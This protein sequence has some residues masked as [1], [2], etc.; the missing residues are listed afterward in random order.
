MN[1][2]RRE[3]IYSILIIVLIPLLFVGNTLLFTSHLRKNFDTE[4]G[5]KA[6][7]VNS[8]IAQSVYEHL[9]DKN[10]QETLDTLVINVKINHPEIQNIRI[11]QQASIGNYDV[12]ANAG[13][14]VG[15]FSGTDFTQFDLAAIH[16]RSVT[17]LIDVTTSTGQDTRAWDTATPII[18]NNK[19][20]VAY[21]S[22]QML[23]TDGDILVDN[24]TNN[25]YWVTLASTIL[26][27]L[28][29]AR[30]FRF[31]TY[32]DLLR[33]QK[34][35]NQTMNDFLNVASHE[36][37]AP[38]TII[39][40]IA[41]NTKD[42]LYGEVPEKIKPQ[43][44]T[45]MDQTMRLST[46]VS[47]LLNISRIQSGK[48]SFD[49][50][51]VNM[52]EIIT[53]LAGNYKQKAAEKNM[54]ITYLPPA[55]LPPV[56]ADAGRVQE[57]ITN[58]IDNALKYSLQ[59]SVVISHE[60]KGNNVITRVKDTGIGMS[61]EERSRLFQRFYRVQNDKTRNIAGT[62]LGLWIIKQYIEKMGGTIDVD[63]I[64]NTGTEFTVT[65]KKA[66]GTEALVTTQVPPAAQAPQA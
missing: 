18:D 44:V 15:K 9:K 26:I 52:A 17:K 20:V 63:S 56:F 35:V 40:G 36:L 28:L 13:D 16:K 37:K 24:T 42:G 60:I 58:L 47:D 32:A 43:L 30:H 4:L 66:T 51:P 23:T 62:G 19:N 55:N 29:L 46:L 14:K 64:I 11:V 22:S 45:I 57:I 41:E 50:K 48:I 2:E 33:R 25:A 1:R 8:I 53:M 6:D 27:I 5:R 34:E 39:S 38:M 7:V 3:I 65:L 61:S 31:I 59:G 54:T 49:M 21:V 10:L 12:I